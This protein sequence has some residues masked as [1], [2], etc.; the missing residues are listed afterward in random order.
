ME[1]SNHEIARVAERF[2]ELASEGKIVDAI[3]FYE[4]ERVFEDGFSPIRPDHKDS[5]TPLMN[6]LYKGLNE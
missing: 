3:E 1:N 4:R 6:E 5:R 2:T